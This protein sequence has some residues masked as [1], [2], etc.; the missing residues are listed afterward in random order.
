MA[1][2]TNT[3]TEEVREALVGVN[4]PADR[5]SL[6]KRANKKNASEEVISSIKGLPDRQFM[7]ESEVMMEIEY[8][9]MKDSVSDSRLD[10][11]LM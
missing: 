1:I 2:H 6:L 10:D 11:D 5:E 4:Y 3:R 7:N 9:D 8:M